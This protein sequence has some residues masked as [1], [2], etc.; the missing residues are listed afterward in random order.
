MVSSF[1][2]LI[3]LIFNWLIDAS[4]MNEN[5]IISKN[6]KLNWRK[7]IHLISNIFYFL[8]HSIQD[9]E[10]LRQIILFSSNNYLI[11]QISIKLS[12]FVSTTTWW[13]YTGW[14]NSSKRF[15]FLPFSIGKFFKPSFLLFNFNAWQSLDISREISNTSSHLVCVLSNFCCLVQ[16]GSP[17]YDC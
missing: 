8:Q 15:D 16:F 14:F 1:C 9:L 12:F 13:E 4:M 3:L 5:L 2:W 11:N 6:F 10:I 17:R 7:S